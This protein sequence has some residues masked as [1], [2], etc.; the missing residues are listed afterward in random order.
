M[1]DQKGFSFGGGLGTGQGKKLLEERKR[2]A[3]K[4]NEL[5]YSNFGDN[6]FLNKIQMK[7]KKKN[8]T[9]YLFLVKI[10]VKTKN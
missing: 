2:M 8:L 7:M 10:A 9:I 1:G 6:Y 4:R 5:Y 3:E